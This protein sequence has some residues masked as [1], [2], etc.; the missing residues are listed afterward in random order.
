MTEPSG[1][2]R[3]AVDRSLSVAL[4]LTRWSAA[5]LVVI[6][7]VRHLMF[8]DLKN[9]VAP[10]IPLKAFY[11]LTGFGHEAVVLFFVISGFLVG[12]TTLQ[13][14]VATGV[15]L[16]RYFAARISRIHTVLVPALVVGGCLDY[17]GLWWFNASE[18]YTD[19]AK[20]RTISLGNTIVSSL[21]LKTFV[22]NVLM[23]QH[24][25]AHNF[26]SNGPLWSL[27]WEWWYYCIFA[28]GA[29][30]ALGSGAVRIAAAAAVAMACILLPGKLLLWGCIWLIGVGVHVWLRSG[31][32]LPPLVPALVG[33][34]VVLTISR[35]THNV[36]N[37]ENHESLLAEFSR[38][39][40]TGAAFA[41]AL[42][43]VGGG[44]WRLPWP[45]FHQKM[46][47]F[48]YSTYLL[49]FP[50]MLFI[51]AVGHQLLGL[52]IHSQPDAAGLACFAAVT[53]L[54]YAVCYSFSRVVEVQTPVVRRAI[55][56]AC[57]IGLRPV[58]PSR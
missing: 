1:D 46:A 5:C 47:D 28:M 32:A 22:L 17:A 56:R 51:V 41:V 24:V 11:F 34:F 6:S 14:W 3:P 54:C 19:P 53:G 37:L 57:G 45:R 27:S 7:H 36:D 50:V 31:R 13:R 26:G 40:M 43:A 21:D 58:R 23:M 8:T 20:Y 42:A 4:D 25:I 15:D 49:H 44:R 10:S 35:V 52:A 30:A 9:V 18:L 16:K 29:L 33:L 55:E 12:G 2:P 48:S 39:L 38:D